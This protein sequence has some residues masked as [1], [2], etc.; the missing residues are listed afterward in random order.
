MIVTYFKKIEKELATETTRLNSVSE[1]RVPYLVYKQYYY[2]YITAEDCFV[3]KTKVTYPQLT[4][5]LSLFEKEGIDGQI[6]T[7]DETEE[8][9]ALIE[10]TEEIAAPIEKD[11]LIKGKNTEL[12]LNTGTTTITSEGVNVAEGNFY[13]EEPFLGTEDKRVDVSEEPIQK[14]KPTRKKKNQA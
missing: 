6:W 3:T 2:A 11:Q 9:V 14:K 13:I 8:L 12:N 10:D 1:E 4:L 5:I 7:M